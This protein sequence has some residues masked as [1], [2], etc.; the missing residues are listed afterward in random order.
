ML[1][2]YQATDIVDNDFISEKRLGIIL[3]VV[4]TSIVLVYARHCSIY[5]KSINSFNPYKNALRE[6]LFLSFIL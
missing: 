5:F 4:N 3:T 2:V 1:I 6:M